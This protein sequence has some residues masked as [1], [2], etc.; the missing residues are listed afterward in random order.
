[1]TPEEYTEKRAML[2]KQL[3]RIPG[4]DEWHR[5]RAKIDRMDEAFELGY[6]G[7]FRGNR[8]DSDA[9]LSM[10]GVV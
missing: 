7:R 10:Y 8:Q 9:R 2:M 5:L 3:N 4:G 6:Y 1:M